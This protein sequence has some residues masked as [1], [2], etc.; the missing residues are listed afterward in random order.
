MKHFTNEQREDI[1][2]LYQE[3][4]SGQ[5]IK[6]TMRLKQ[7]VRSIQRVVHNEGISRPIGEAFRNAIKRGRIR[8]V[9]KEKRVHRTKLN[10]TL[11]Y[12]ILDRDNFKCVKCGAT[13]KD[14]LIEVDHKD[15]NPSNQDP[16][17]LETLCHRCNF[18][19]PS[20][21]RANQT[22]KSGIL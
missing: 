8:Y 2:D 12:K 4:S 17:N 14:D 5:E 20:P 6:E 15:N 18:G 10:P 13:A 9:L 21:N 11:R 22:T 3:G 1:I 19:K 7:T 16:N